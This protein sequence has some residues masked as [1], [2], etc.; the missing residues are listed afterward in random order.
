MANHGYDKAPPGAFAQKRNNMILLL[1]ALS[2]AAFLGTFVVGEGYFRWVASAKRVASQ[3]DV[4]S[5]ELKRLRA[6]QDEILNTYGIVSDS[7]RAV[8]I[9]IERAMELVVQERGGR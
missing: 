2:M 4:A 3:T 9:P 7:T 8:R 5:P 1:G 6:Q